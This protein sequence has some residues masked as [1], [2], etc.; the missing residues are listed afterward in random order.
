MDKLNRSF[1][2]NETIS[3]GKSIIT[4][5]TAN[6]SNASPFTIAVKQAERYCQVESNPLKHI[7]K[8]EGKNLSPSQVAKEMLL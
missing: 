6:Y 2:I 7:I 3:Q 4:T 1:D 5:D 8:E